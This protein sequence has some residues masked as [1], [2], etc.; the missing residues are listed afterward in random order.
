VDLQ[1]VAAAA[2]EPGAELGEGVELGS[3]R[4]QSYMRAQ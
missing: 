2:V 4:R 3:Q 1:R